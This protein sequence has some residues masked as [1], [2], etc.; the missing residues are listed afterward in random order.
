VGSLRLARRQVYNGGHPFD[1]TIEKLA[2]G[3]TLCPYHDHAT[4]WELF[5]ITSGSGTVR[6][7][8]E[9]HAV[10]TG[11]VIAHP[12]GDAHQIIN[13]GEIDLTYILIA[14]NP[15]V[16]VCRYPDSKKVGIY[17]DGDRRELFRATEVDYWDGEE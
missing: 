4:Q 11:D 8:G 9:S 1:L 15:P 13:T 14:D 10:T 6:S 5:F 16:D 7:N 2:P 3:D 17:D 12:P